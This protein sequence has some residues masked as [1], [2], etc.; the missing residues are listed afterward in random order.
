[1]RHDEAY[2]QAMLE[3]EHEAIEALNRCIA[4]GAKQEDI[5]TLARECGIDINHLTLDADRRA[6]GVGR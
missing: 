3:R 4:A 6:A 2:H 1:M 5:R